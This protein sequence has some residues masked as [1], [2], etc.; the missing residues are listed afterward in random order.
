MGLVSRLATFICLSVVGAYFIPGSPLP[1][2]LAAELATAALKFAYL[3]SIAFSIGVA[4]WQSF[5]FGLVAFKTLP[6]QSFGLLQSK[7]FPIYF[8]VTS[9]W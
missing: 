6:R 4:D 9:D 7:L 8:Q 3:F 1:N 2:F 5:V